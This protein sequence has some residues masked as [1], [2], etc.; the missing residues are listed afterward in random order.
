MAEVS[1]EG[2]SATGR[3]YEVSDNAV[4]KWARQ[5]EAELGTEDAD[6]LRPPS[7]RSRWEGGRPPM[8]PSDRLDG[9]GAR[10]ALSLLA[11][12][13]TPI[14]VAERLGVSKWCIYTL[15]RGESHRWLKRPDERE[16]T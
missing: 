15:R 7:L 5:Y 3:R 8:R 16:S 1:A 10:H 12:G 11:V 13:R 6:A 9:N 2:W 14:E 4:K